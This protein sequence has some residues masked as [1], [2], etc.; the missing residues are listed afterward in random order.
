[1]W[2]WQSRQEGQGNCYVLVTVDSLLIW[3]WWAG[4]VAVTFG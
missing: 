1:M 3:Q 4:D 2:I